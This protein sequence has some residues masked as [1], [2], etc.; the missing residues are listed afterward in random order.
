M[1][2]AKPHCIFHKAPVGIIS[3]Q[4]LPEADPLMFLDRSPGMQ[5]SE[6]LSDC[7]KRNIG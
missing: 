4:R 1:E 7:F 6:D 3:T 2:N 5:I